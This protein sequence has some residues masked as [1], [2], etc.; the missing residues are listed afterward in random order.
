[1]KNIELFDEYTTIVMAQ[2]YE[3]FPIK[4][5]IDARNLCGHSD[6]DEYGGVVDASGRPSKAFD[7]AMATIEWLG[8][9]GY[10]RYKERW[11]FGWTDV[12]LTEKGLTMLKALPNSLASKETFGDRLLRLVKEGSISLAKEAAKAAFDSLAK[13]FTPC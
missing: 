4:K 11:A 8:D 9:N 2:L 10:A 6:I 5:T 7:L 1:M 3:S 13:Q 12:V